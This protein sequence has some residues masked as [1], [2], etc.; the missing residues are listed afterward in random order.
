[1]A[2]PSILETLHGAPAPADE[3]QLEEYLSRPRRP[4]I[5][6]MADL[7]GDLLVLGAGGKMG[8]SFAAMAARSL[9][10]AG[11]SGRVIAVSRFHDGVER[12]HAAGVE[13]IETDLLDD[14]EAS[15]SVAYY[16]LRRQ[17]VGRRRDEGVAERVHAGRPMSRT[18]SSSRSR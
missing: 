7:R 2:E 12:F 9:R 8:L 3:D 6:A 1:M 14:R 5:E 18:R 13:T 4:T 11:T 17:Y 16:D 10:A 15:A